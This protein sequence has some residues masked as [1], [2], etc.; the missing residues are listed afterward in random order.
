[1][2]VQIGSEISHVALSKVGKR[3]FPIIDVNENDPYKARLTEFLEGQNLE[4][5]RLV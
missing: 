1:V 5:I 3:L 4:L 2:I